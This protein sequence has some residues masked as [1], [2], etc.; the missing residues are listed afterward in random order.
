MKRLGGT[1]WQFRLFCFNTILGNTFGAG[2]PTNPDLS[3]AEKYGIQSM[4]A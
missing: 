1:L 3:L 2:D 4:T